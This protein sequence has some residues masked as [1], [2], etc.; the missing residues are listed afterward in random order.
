MSTAFAAVNLLL[1]ISIFTFLP[2]LVGVYVYRDAKR[3]NMNA[4]LWTIIAILAPSLI[5]FI[6][7]LLV[8][9]NYSNLKCP[10][11][12]ATV[13]EQ[14]VVCPKCGAK[15][16]PSCPNCST[17]VEPDWTVCPKCAQP[18]P[19][20]QEDIVAPIRPKDK[21]LWKILAAIIIIP[22]VLILAFGTFFSI[23]SGSTSFREVSLDTYFNDQELPQSTQDYVREWISNLPNDK[24]HV[25]ALRYR[26]QVLED[27]KEK[28]YYYLIY[29]PGCG[30][31]SSNSFG[32]SSGLFGLGDELR[33]ELNGHGI[34][35][36]FYC[37]TI[38]EKKHAPGIRVSLNG[39]RLEDVVTVVDFNPTLYTIASES[40]YSMLTNAAGD[41]YVEQLEK[42]MEPN[43]V[44]ITVVE[45]GQ[46][47]AAG[48]Y[49]AP[50]FLLNTVTDI[51]ELHHLDETPS[52]LNGY[53][54][55]N[56]SMLS[57]HYADTTGEAHYEDTCDYLT[58]ESDGTYYLLE[59]RADRQI[60]DILAKGQ[61]ADKDDV[62]AYE[63][64]AEAYAVLHGLFE[65]P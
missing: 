23:N 54:L 41:L 43:L 4:P 37:M 50:D 38:S 9:G 58:I 49:D 64:S 5:G 55:S 22:I 32:Y 51:H 53:Q 1:V 46:E 65:K 24:N 15:L 52:F 28:D 17:P 35:E 42:E 44:T 27:S 26:Y 47:V 16:K 25:Y 61:I 30:S 56:Y 39:K 59:I 31:V 18:L 62:L 10:R 34:E 7:Y 6:I 40:D 3:R 48:E 45:D 8:R 20:I 19:E 60:E 29:I 63:I 33:L 14:Y 57:I 13:T 36:S 11:C 21:T 12:D 2:I